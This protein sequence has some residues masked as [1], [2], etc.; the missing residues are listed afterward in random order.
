M[1]YDGTDIKIMRIRSGIKAIELAKQIGISNVK[2]SLIENNRI[3]V[4]KDVLEKI[5]AALTK[6]VK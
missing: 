5:Q 1:P 6:K 4:S 2:L 3:D